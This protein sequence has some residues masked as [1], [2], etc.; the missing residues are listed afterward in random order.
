MST[1]SGSRSERRRTVIAA[2]VSTAALLVLLAALAA[3]ALM[4]LGA[5]RLMRKKVTNRG[6]A[7]QVSTKG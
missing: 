3:V 5:T 1:K 4:T 7:E 2:V 6:T